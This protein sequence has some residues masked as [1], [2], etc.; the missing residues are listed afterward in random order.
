MNWNIGKGSF[1]AVLICSIGL[2]GCASG[3]HDRNNDV[4]AR[5]AGERIH[6][7]G[8]RDHSK[9]DG[10]FSWEGSGGWDNQGSNEGHHIKR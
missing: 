5:P 7:Y 2:G 8:D 6:P 3:Q 9:D 4:S 10:V 1:A